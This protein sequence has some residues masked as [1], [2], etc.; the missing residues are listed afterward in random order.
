MFNSL[1]LNLIY[2]LLFLKCL[3]SLDD[4]TITQVDSTETP[5]ISESGWLLGKKLDHASH[6]PKKTL[7]VSLEDLIGSPSVLS[8]LEEQQE[9]EDFMQEIE[10]Q[11]PKKEATPEPTNEKE[12][13]DELDT[14]PPT[15]PRQN[16]DKEDETPEEMMFEMD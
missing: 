5:S 16:A 4:G 14:N 11:H 8:R 10:S 3:V 15:N 13:E 9:V 12:D 7:A 6:T 1:T 2:L